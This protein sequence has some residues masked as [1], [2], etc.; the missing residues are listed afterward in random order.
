VGE[1]E[2]EE[3]ERQRG[4]QRMS[5]NGEGKGKV[6]GGVWRRTV[7]DGGAKKRL[8]RKRRISEI[9]SFCIMC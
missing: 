8:R 5:G 7:E 3:R 6:G 1:G 2:G 9:A 4:G